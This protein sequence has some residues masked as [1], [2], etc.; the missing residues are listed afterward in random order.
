MGAVSGSGGSSELSDILVQFP[1]AVGVEVAFAKA[2]L[3]LVFRPNVREDVHAREVHPGER[4]RS[5]LCLFGDEVRTCLGCFVVDSLHALDGQWSRVLD[6]AIRE[7]VNDCFGIVG[8]EKAGVVAGPIRT[9]RLFFGV[10]V[11]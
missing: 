9:L 5:R 8:L 1:R 2:R 11:V 4:W 10:E 3:T 7:R 6:L